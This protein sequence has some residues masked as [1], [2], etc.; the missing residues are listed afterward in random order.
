MKN[1]QI[2][3]DHTTSFKSTSFLLNQGILVDSFAAQNGFFESAPIDKTALQERMRFN[4]TNVGF[5]LIELVVSIAIIAILAG[6]LLPSLA[7]AKQ[8]VKRTSC[9][10]NLR[11]LATSSLMYA[12]D[13][14]KKS[15]SGRTG[16]DDQ[17]LNYLLPYVSKS[18]NVFVCPSTQN[19]VSSNEGFNPVS[20][21]RGLVDLF[22]PAGG[23]NKTSRMSYM[24]NAFIGHGTPYSEDIPFSGKTRHLPYLRKDLS[25]VQTYVTWHNAFGLRGVTAGASRHW[26][27]EDDYWGGDI[28]GYPDKADNHGDQGL[29]VSFCDGHVE[30]LATRGF[31]YG[32]ELDT[33]EGRTG[34][35]MPY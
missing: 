18:L 24:C 21:E 12:D 33:D 9:I 11:Q 35:A 23:R 6:L 15:L 2:G 10:A 26:L 16:A 29:N 22:G 20:G 13:D 31:L 34:I 4:L 27:V 14:I 28:I 8:K 19:A 25:N 32:Y 5:T 1:N 3:Y 17:S 7:S 30:W